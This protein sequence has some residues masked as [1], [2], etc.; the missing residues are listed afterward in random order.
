MVGRGEDEQANRII[1][2][3]RFF[4]FDCT[5][6]PLVLQ[7]VLYSYPPTVKSCNYSSNIIPK[8]SRTCGLSLPVSLVYHSLQQKPCTRSSRPKV[9]PIRH[10]TLKGETEEH[11][12]AEKQKNILSTKVKTIAPICL[13]LR[14]SDYSKYLVKTPTLIKAK[15]KQK[16]WRGC[17]DSIINQKNRKCIWEYFK[18]GF[19]KYYCGWPMMVG[20]AVN[21]TFKVSTRIHGWELVWIIETFMGRT[22]SL[23]RLMRSE[24]YHRSLPM[25]NWLVGNRQYPNPM[26]SCNSWY[27]HSWN[28]HRGVLNLGANTNIFRVEVTIR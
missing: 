23:S 2:Q 11:K 3:V 17:I 26:D 25:V 4:F 19:R 10:Q 5:V 16:L 20:V 8:W 1:W 27:P 21:S 28:Y 9:W 18:Q 15:T 14:N 24:T 6:A 13:A 12:S 22:I 7:P